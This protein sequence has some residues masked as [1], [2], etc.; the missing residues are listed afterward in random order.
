MRQ[1]KALPPPA[2]AL[3]P[4]ADAQLASL[5]S[6][7]RGG[8]GP[9]LALGDTV[10]MPLRG[11]KKVPMFPHKRAGGWGWDQADAFLAAKPRHAGWALLLDRACV[12]DTDSPEAVKRLEDLGLPELRSCPMQL[13]SKGRHYFF[14]RPDWADAEGFFDGARQHGDAGIEADLKT[15]C[16]TGTRGVLVVAPTPGK[17]WA[18]GRAPWEAQ[19]AEVPR[20]LLELVAKPVAVVPGRG[21]GRAKAAALSVAAVVSDTDVEADSALT[22]DQARMLMGVGQLVRML[23]PAR[24]DS[25]ADWMRVGWC[26]RNVAADEGGSRPAFVAACLDAWAAFSRLSVKHVEGEPAARWAAMDVRGPEQRKLGLG[27]LRMWAREDAPAEFALWSREG[28]PASDMAGS[29]LTALN[30]RF[31]GLGLS[32]A[33]GDFRVVRV[34]EA[35]LTFEDATSGLTGTV[36]APKPGYW[37]HTVS[38][39]GGPD[40][41]TRF[42]GLLQGDVPV[43]GTVSHLHRNIPVAADNF[44]FNQPDEDRAV[45]SS[46]TPNV[47]AEI[48]LHRPKAGDSCLSIVVPTGGHATVCAKSKVDNF[49]SRVCE[50][51]AKHNTLNLFVNNLTIV[52]NTGCTAGASQTDNALIT[53]VLAARPELRERVCFSPESKTGNCNGLFYCDPATNV[54]QQRHNVA[55]EEILVDM[56]K[57]LPGLSPA[58]IRHVESRRGRA[59]MVHLLAAKVLD[60]R[61]RDRL[62]ANPDLFAVA[63]GCFA[64]QGCVCPTFRELRPDDCVSITSGWAYSKDQAV[65]ARPDLEDFLAKV[66]PVPEERKVVLAYF[67][68]LLSGRRTAKKMLVMTDRRS[69]NNGKSTLMALMG[70]FFGEYAESSKGTKFVCKGSFERDRDSHDA[71]LEPFR[72]KRLVVAEELKSCMT[73]DVG[74]LKRV[75]GGADVMV[76]GRSFGAKETFRF[77]WQAGIVL[78]FNEGDCPTYDMS[79]SAFHGRLLFAPMR[80]KFVKDAC[81]ND[82]EPW[83]Y[84]VDATMSSRF[85]GW[86]SALADVLVEHYGVVGCFDTPPLSMH[87]WRKD[88]TADANPIA[89]WCEE[90]FEVTGNMSDSVALGELGHR[91]PP[92]PKYKQLVKAFYAGVKEVVYVDRVTAKRNIVK[93]VR[94]KPLFEAAL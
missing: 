45:L 38:V 18:T 88:V 21:R 33:P 8:S 35:G 23:S 84:E 50:A 52:N 80:S 82:A 46:V 29:L 3:Q 34:D 44:V 75:A 67:A 86:L 11:G 40:A 30:A 24:A 58:D 7:L 48:T 59:D 94:L 37:G 62:D 25:E 49:R 54:W 22:A 60:E 87:E 53:S 39:R 1:H 77:L 41:P 57:E 15:R 92:F 83:T 66:L 55:I 28:G 64:F 10:L 70:M 74:M 81:T 56:F 78:I 79:D 4:M 2:Y 16:S 61:L 89:Q 43:R 42:L 71:G 36:D 13:T 6:W 12:V 20:T 85:P 27:S 73:L 19:W 65:A 31:P 76:G 72:G 68:S 90:N 63:N 17:A 93:G 69:G 51:F 9:A 14:L 5:V 26:L 47:P 91:R 32:T